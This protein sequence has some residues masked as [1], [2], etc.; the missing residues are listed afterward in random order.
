[1]DQARPDG[2]PSLN[3]ALPHLE[4]EPWFL[5]QLA[6]LAAASR[7]TLAGWLTA[8]ARLARVVVAALAVL[9]VAASGAYAAERISTGRSLLPDQGTHPVVPQHKPLQHHRPASSPTP[10]SGA[11]DSS[12]GGQHNGSGTSGQHGHDGKT[13]GPGSNDGGS[14][15]SGGSGQRNAGS[16]DHAAGGGP[17]IPGSHSGGSDGS[18][19]G[20]PSGDAQLSGN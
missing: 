11:T 4:P 20:G 2:V 9:T 8:R 14:G 1:M 15:S 12:D 18:L 7:P 3:A 5:E 17:S 13:T 16:P 6:E 10:G 19:H